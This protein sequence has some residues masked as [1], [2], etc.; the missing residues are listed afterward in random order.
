VIKVVAAQKASAPAIRR[1]IE[2]IL[3]RI[4]LVAF[5]LVEKL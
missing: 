1:T 3:I 2:V 5:K 4:S